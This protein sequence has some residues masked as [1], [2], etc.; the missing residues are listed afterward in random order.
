MG[1]GNKILGAYSGQ[2]KLY[3]AK[4]TPTWTTLAATANAGDSTI[5]ISETT[6]WK[7]GDK[8]VIAITGRNRDE[9]ETRYI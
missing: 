2:I 4:K 8:L 9:F 7:V 6:N 1:M 5:T 3:G